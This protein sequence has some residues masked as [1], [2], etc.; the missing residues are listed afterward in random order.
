MQV[1]NLVLG[2]F[3]TNCYVLRHDPGVS[4]CLVID[5]GLEA[6][7][8]VDFLQTHELDPAALILTHGHADH[9]AGVVELRKNFPIVKVYI[10][11]LDSDMLTGEQDN[12]SMLAGGVFRAEPAD[13]LLQEGD[14]LEQADIKLEVLHTPGHTPGGICLYCRQ[15]G[16]VF[17]GDTL[18]AGSVGRTDFPAGSMTQLIKSIKEKLFALPDETVVYPGHGPT[19][20]IAREKAYNPFVR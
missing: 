15:Q 12:L 3:E 5:T 7:P 1:D 6:G 19:T 13:S 4:Q 14:V 2:A 11:R 9:I 16:I 8:L 10:H 20:T 18:F 17:V